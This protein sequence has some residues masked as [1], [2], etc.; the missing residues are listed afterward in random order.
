LVADGEE[1]GADEADEEDEEEAEGAEGEGE[2]NGNAMAEDSEMA[3]AETGAANA[4]EDVSDDGSEDL[5]G[6]SSGSEEEEVEEEEEGEG[7]EA[8]EVDDTEKP[9]G[10]ATTSTEHQ[11]DE[12]M[13]H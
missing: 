8:M 11:M 1:Y 3:G 7:D 9:V 10:E 5:E 12:V 13:V 2:A 6:E 4:V